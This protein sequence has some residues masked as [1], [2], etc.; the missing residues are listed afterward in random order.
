MEVQIT[1]SVMKQIHRVVRVRVAERA[2]L[3]GGGVEVELG[4][5]E[6]MKR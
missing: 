5:K 2:P 6:H 4:L 1:V 3:Y